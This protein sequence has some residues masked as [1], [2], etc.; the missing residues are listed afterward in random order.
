MSASACVHLADYI[1]E[2]SF[3]S[4]KLVHAYF[5]ACVNVEARK[6]KVHA[7]FKKTFRFILLLALPVIHRFIFFGA[8]LGS[9]M[10]LLRLRQVRPES[11]FV[12]AL[13]LFCLQG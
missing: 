1:K 5:S 9:L 6:R 2:F 8:D 13:H 12:S 10:F 7:F 11:L 3:D 4:Y